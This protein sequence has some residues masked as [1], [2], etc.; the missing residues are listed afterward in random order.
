MSVFRRSGG[1]GTGTS[2]CQAL[3]FIRVGNITLASCHSCFPSFSR[4]SVVGVEF[5]GTLRTRVEDRGSLIGATH[6]SLA[7]LHLGVVALGTFFVGVLLCARN[8]LGDRKRGEAIALALEGRGIVGWTR[9]CARL[10]WP[11][12]WGGQWKLFLA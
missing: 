10:I 6:L 3:T 4:R 7:E 8:V 12:I 5:V 9:D 2:Y 1:H 11:F